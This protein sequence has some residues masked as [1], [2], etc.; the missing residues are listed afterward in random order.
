M[1]EECTVS[2]DNNESRIIM[3]TVMEENGK[4]KSAKVY[5]GRKE[6]NRECF[7]YE[8]KQ[9]AKKRFSSIRS[10]CNE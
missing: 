10:N 2:N 8:M 9:L 3:D 4:P 6:K 5:N 7:S 1:S